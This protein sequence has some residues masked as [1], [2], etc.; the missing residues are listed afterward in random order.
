MR[1]KCW[2]LTLHGR[3]SS[4]VMT[5]AI[6]KQRKYLS[7]RGQGQYQSWPCPTSIFSHQH[8]RNHVGAV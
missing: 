4:T 1:Q 7:N 8:I 5:G 3:S 2:S 6:K